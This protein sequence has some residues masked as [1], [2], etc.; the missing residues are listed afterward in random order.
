MT[1]AR[2]I[3]RHHG[4]ILAT[5]VSVPEVPNRQV[6]LLLTRVNDGQ[7]EAFLPPGQKGNPA[8]GIA[9][10]ITETANGQTPTQAARR[11]CFA[12]FRLLLDEGRYTVVTSKEIPVVLVTAAIGLEESAKIRITPRQSAQRYWRNL[13]DCLAGRYACG[14]G[15][16][17]WLAVLGK[18]LNMPKP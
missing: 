3:S 10:V 15:L 8:P 1:S 12:R 7:Q 4:G 2:R 5:P 6:V 17:E 13:A 9:S 14:E 16:K 11:F 18:H